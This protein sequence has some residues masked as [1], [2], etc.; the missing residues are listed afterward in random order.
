M[1]AGPGGFGF[2]R[3][4]EKPK[5]CAAS[6][7]GAGPDDADAEVDVA[8]GAATKGAAATAGPDSLV[9]SRARP[10]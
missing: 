10:S 4:G 8:S 5:F 7:A 2:I 9:D 3:A 1:A 6:A